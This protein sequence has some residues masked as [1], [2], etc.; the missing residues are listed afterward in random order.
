MVIHHMWVA[1]TSALI[2]AYLLYDSAGYAGIIGIAPVF[3]VVPL[4]STNFGYFR[5]CMN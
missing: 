3:L 1:P 4:Q 5:I 2:V